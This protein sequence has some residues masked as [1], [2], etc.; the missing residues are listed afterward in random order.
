M[1]GTLAARTEYQSIAVAALRRRRGD[2]ARCSAGPGEVHYLIVGFFGR[3]INHSVTIHPSRSHRLTVPC[4][5]DTKECR[6][7]GSVFVGRFELPVR[8]G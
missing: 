1:V 6:I 3:S 5:D 7:F 4:I 8:I 2:K